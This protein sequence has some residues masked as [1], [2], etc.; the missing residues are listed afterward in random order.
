M[1]PRTSE[2]LSTPLAA[3]PVAAE[4][5]EEVVITHH[6]GTFNDQTLDYCA[7][8]GTMVL[9]EESEKDGTREGEKPAPLCFTPPTPTLD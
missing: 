1:P 9:R 4:A 6:R 8:C 5:Q 7:T 2:S 3:C